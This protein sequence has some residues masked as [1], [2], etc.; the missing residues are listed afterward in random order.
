MPKPIDAKAMPAINWGMCGETAISTPGGNVCQLEVIFADAGTSCT[1]TC[2]RLCV[3]K[4]S[5][6]ANDITLVQNCIGEM[7]DL[8]TNL[9]DYRP[10]NENED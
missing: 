6:T 2:G 9:M 7:D 5:V 3:S 8:I 10:Q 1:V 4:S